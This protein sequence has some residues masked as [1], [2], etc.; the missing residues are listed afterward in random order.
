MV[1]V[2][3]LRNTFCSLIPLAFLNLF[4]NFIRK[5]KLLGFDFLF[6]LNVDLV[7]SKDAFT[8]LR[9]QGW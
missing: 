7:D 1:V 4:E 5:S 6:S 3:L 8:E 2:P 9:L